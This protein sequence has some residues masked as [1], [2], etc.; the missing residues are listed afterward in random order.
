MNIW[1]PLGRLFGGLHMAMHGSG[2]IWFA[3]VGGN[4]VFAVVF[5]PTN[6]RSQKRFGHVAGTQVI[7]RAMESD[8]A[9]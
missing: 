7:G 6:A 4:L 8:G 5:G 9:C 2:P 3:P 1:R